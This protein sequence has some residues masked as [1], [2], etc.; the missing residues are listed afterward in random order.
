[1]AIRLVIFEDSETLRNSLSTLLGSSE[2]YDVVGM[3]GDVLEV[4]SIIRSTRP[5][6]VILD[7]DMP[8]RDGISAIP[9]IKEIDSKISVVMYTQFEDEDRLFRSLCAG[10]DGY[11]LKKTNPL[12]LFEAIAEVHKGGVPMSPAIAQKVLNSF[13]EKAKPTQE[14][15]FLT[16]RETEVLQQL[17]KGYSV[18]Y[19]AADLNMAYETCRSHLRN[20]YKKLHVQCGKEAI[21]KVLKG[22]I[23]LRR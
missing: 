1:M 2:S 19:I 8:A 5:D 12:K 9:I 4:E 10:A 6:V 13:R 18:K 15:Y 7:I 3:Y 22:G 11:V 23:Y 14:E 21:A 16:D 20:I 17:V